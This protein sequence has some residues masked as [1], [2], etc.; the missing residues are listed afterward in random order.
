MKHTLLIIFSIFYFAIMSVSA[1]E[2]SITEKYIEI[3]NIDTFFT[4]K[5]NL[6]EISEFHIKNF[7]EN[8]S[9]KP[10]HIGVNELPNV[11]KFGIAGHSESNHRQRRCY[12]RM[13]K[14]NYQETFYK[15]LKTL[16]IRY[17]LYANQAYEI[18]DFHQ[19]LL[20]Y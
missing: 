17:V 5:E 12:I 8:E 1:Q 20:T 2:N 11:I 9:S 6:I 16:N 10:Y 14:S 3:Q 13:E 7:D 18:E 19:I 15:T 4:E